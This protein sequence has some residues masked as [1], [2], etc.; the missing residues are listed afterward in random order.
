MEDRSWRGLFTTSPGALSNLEAHSKLPNGAMESFP[1]D[2]LSPGRQ[3]D[4][5]RSDKNQGAAS[6]CGKPPGV[7]SCWAI[8]AGDNFSLLLPD[9]VAT[10]G[11]L[12]SLKEHVLLL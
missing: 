2:G 6:S 9:F 10:C 3:A 5:E 12:I 4:G 8:S 1:L 7:L 11:H